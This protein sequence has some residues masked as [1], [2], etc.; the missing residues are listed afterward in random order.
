[1]LATAEIRNLLQNTKIERVLGGNLLPANNNSSFLSLEDVYTVTVVEDNPKGSIPIAFGLFNRC[2]PNQVYCAVITLK[3]GYETNFV[4][5]ERVKNE[6][7]ID[8]EDV[9]RHSCY[10]VNKLHSKVLNSHQI[11][12]FSG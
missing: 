12:D 11:L 4:A 2:S 10:R 9:R 3:K 8:A 5:I 1:M 7:G 6:M